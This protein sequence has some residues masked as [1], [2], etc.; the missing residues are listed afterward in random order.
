VFDIKTFILVIVLGN[1]CFALMASLYIHSRFD[2]LPGL[3]IWRWGKVV[4]GIGLGMA[5]V[6]HHLPPL[7]AFSLGHTLLFVGWCME[8]LG[9]ARLLER[10]N[11]PASHQLLFIWLLSTLA[12]FILLAGL[13]HPEAATLTSII[14]GL[15]YAGMALLV[16]GA[17]KK[18]GVL[19][20]VIGVVDALMSFVFFIRASKSLLT[21]NL[22]PWASDEI[23]LAMYFMAVITQMCNG[24]GFLLLAQQRLDARLHL[25]LDEVRQAE[26][27]QRELLSMAAHEFRTP[28][29]MIM[30]SLDSLNILK[31]KIPDEVALRLD[32]IRQSTRRMNE[33]TSSLISQDRLQDR[34]FNLQTEA[35]S[36]QQLLGKLADDYPEERLHL[37]LPDADMTLMADPVLLGIAVHNLI[38]NALRHDRL[39]EIIIGFSAVDRKKWLEIIVTD[40]GTGIPDALKAR[41]FERFN[42]TLQAQRPGGLGLS[43]VRKIIL[44]H[45]GEVL[46]RD[47]P[48][49]G[50]TF[51]LRLP[52]V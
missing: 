33:L 36:L 32:N 46:V 10:F 35:V 19:A 52:A 34:V 47:T 2:S 5:L 11:R 26:A 17:R 6:R 3:S 42:S 4:L 16:F 29:A 21:G 23:N 12:L 48:G 30:S 22:V 8:L 1:L 31:D 9:Y 18:Y 40:H 38:D 50:A 7:L 49:G 39:G 15:M 27:E 24:F 13:S 37:S 20:V 44:A 45:G 14:G 51:V 28:A 41:V 43:I 25:A